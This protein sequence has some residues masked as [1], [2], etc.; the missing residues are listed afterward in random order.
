M[1]AGS[2]GNMRAND[3]DREAVR[4]QLADAHAEGRL[5]WEEFDAR[6]SALLSSQTYGQLAE[7]T[8][9]LPAKVPGQA[10]DHYA[11]LPGRH[12][13]NG[14]AVAS[15]VCGICGFV[16]FVGSVPAVILGHASLR[17]MRRTGEHG[18]A[19][20]VIGLVFGYVGL[21]FWLLAVA[22][23]FAFAGGGPAPG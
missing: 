8:A 3:S 5:S 10:L 23:G 18:Q 6:T 2:F 9:D 15:L 17:Q 11:A 13:T 12:G 14:M 16:P 1:T 20:A 7:L 22:V 19:M 4:A 21:V